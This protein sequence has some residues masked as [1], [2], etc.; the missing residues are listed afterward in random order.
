MT[1]R[2]RGWPLLRLLALAGH[3]TGNRFRRVL[4]EEDGMSPGAAA[5]LT[6]LA[7][8]SGRGLSTGTPGRAT[9]SDLANRCLIAPATLTGIVST[10]EKAGYVRR[11]RDTA[12]R[13]VVW[14][15]ITESGSTRAQEIGRRASAANTELVRDLTPDI[16]QALRDFLIT[17]IESDLAVFQEAPA[18]TDHRPPSAQHSESRPRC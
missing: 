8:G 4:A 13:R 12:D 17:V 11:E 10:L 5:V 1:E 18:L 3:A 6:M 16:E 9:H 15:V 2:L 14:L 7:W